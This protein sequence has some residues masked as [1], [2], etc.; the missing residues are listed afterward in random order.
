MTNTLAYYEHPQIT[1]TKSFIVQAR[2]KPNS[3]TCEKHELAIWQLEF[4]P[5]VNFLPGYCWQLISI[6]HLT[7]ML[8]EGEKTQYS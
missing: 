6:H 3:S 2:G 7:G 4:V 8:T 5:I 1:A